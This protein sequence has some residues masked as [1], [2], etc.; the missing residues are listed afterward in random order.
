MQRTTIQRQYKDRLFRMAFRD[1][2]HLLALYNAINGSDYKDP[3][4][5]EIRTLEDAIYMGMKND[6]S[7]ILDDILNL[8]EQ[9]SSFNPNMP[10]RGLSYF[11]R[12]YQSYIE[13]HKINIYSSKLR[14]LPF[15]QYIIF[16]NG[17]RQKEDRTELK[18][19]DAFYGDKQKLKDRKPCLEV[20]AL[21][22]NINWG[23]NKE[24]MVQCR[25]LQEYSQCIAVIR[26]YE[27]KIADRQ[28]A[29]A[30][31]VDKC[32]AEGLLADILSKNRAEVISL[33]LTE[34]DE[35]AQREL[36]RAEAREDGWNEGREAGMKAGMEAGMEAGMKAGMEEGMKAGRAKGFIHLVRKK[37]LKGISVQD[38]AEML[39]EPEELIQTIY[40]AIRNHPEWTEDE[41]YENSLKSKEMDENYEPDTRGKVSGRY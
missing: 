12:L 37:A 39:E 3:D 11:A 29:V 26:E 10:V 38:T 28:E 33:F 1:K 7:F 15:P 9:Q 32:I 8:Y 30:K 16:Y 13:E 41:I 24:L 27:A 25:R 5:L 20:R 40:D 35:Q 17:S 14:R 2:E 21:M 34:Y 22:L 4:E 6:A 36:D 23:H 19:S 31:A 18:L